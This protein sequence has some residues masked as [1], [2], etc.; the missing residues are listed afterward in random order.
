MKNELSFDYLTKRIKKNDFWTF[1]AVETVQAF[2]EYC[3]CLSRRIKVVSVYD[4]F[5]VFKTKSFLVYKVFNYK[6]EL[7]DRSSYFEYMKQTRGL[8]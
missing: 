1:E 6:G 3:S 5:I 7:V 4:G 2:K 8:K